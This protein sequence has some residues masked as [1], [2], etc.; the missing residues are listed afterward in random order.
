MAEGIVCARCKATKLEAGFPPDKRKANGL[1]SWCRDC[2]KE[3]VR[4]RKAQY[5]GAQREARYGISIEAQ[6]ALYEA[7]NGKCG[8][9]KGPIE[10]DTAHLDHD[11]KTG[12][13]RGFLCAPCN[14]TLGHGLEDR[15]RLLGLVAYL[16]AHQ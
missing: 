5:Q 7:Q 8:G 1:H 9:C 14:R 12:R 10:M 2:I 13:V 3:Y 4:E 15:H 6:Y 11:H 16:D